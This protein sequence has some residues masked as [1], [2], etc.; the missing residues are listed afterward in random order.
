MSTAIQN[1]M[2]PLDSIDFRATGFRVDLNDEAREMRVVL[3]KGKTERPEDVLGYLIVSPE[4]G[5]E[6]AQKL[7]SGYD[8]LEG[9]KVKP[10]A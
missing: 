5:Y 9:I 2:N 1:G 3:F 6:M 7:L 8:E 10:R 4:D